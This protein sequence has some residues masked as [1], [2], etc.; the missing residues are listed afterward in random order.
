MDFVRP[1][2]EKLGISFFRCWF[3]KYIY[4]YIYIYLHLKIPKMGPLSLIPKLAPRFVSLIK[5]GFFF[6]L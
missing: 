4:I 5:L 2:L 3:R 1:I 6:F